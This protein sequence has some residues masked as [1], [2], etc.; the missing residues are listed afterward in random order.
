M[1][2]VFLHAAHNFFAQKTLQYEQ[3]NVKECCKGTYED[4]YFGNNCFQQIS[5]IELIYEKNSS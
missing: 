2:Y 3:K 5:Q 4:E 1:K